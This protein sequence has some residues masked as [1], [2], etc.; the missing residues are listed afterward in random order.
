MPIKLIERQPTIQ[1]DYSGSS[2]LVHLISR[3]RNQLIS[4][5]GTAVCLTKENGLTSIKSRGG[6]INSD[7]LWVA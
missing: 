7:T 1:L 4:I 5:E 3:E 6:E 2:N